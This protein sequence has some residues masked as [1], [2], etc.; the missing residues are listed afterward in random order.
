[1]KIAVTDLEIE[2][3]WVIYPGNKPYKLSENITVFPLENF[4]DVWKYE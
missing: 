4:Q 3:L 2:H 1:M